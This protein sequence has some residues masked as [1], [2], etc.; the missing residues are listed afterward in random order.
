MGGKSIKTFVNSIP[1]G[2]GD[3]PRDGLLELAD[4]CPYDESNPDDCPLFSLRKLPPK[5]RLR[6]LGALSEEDWGYLVAYHHVCLGVRVETGL[7]ELR[8]KAPGE[9]ET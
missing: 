9:R 3:R 5:K 1:H 4:F 2:R 8:A 7:A 6:W